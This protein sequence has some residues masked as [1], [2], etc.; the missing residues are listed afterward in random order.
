MVTGDLGEV[1]FQDGD[2]ASEGHMAATTEE[3][4][5]WEAEDGGHQG[6]VRDS[7]ETLDTALKA[8]C[9]HRRGGE[10]S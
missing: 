3:G 8:T 4:H 10:Q 7:A 1:V 5:S 6:G 9:T 2:G